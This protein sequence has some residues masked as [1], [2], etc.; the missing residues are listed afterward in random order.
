M[1][2]GQAPS[3]SQRRKSLQS[4]GKRGA[5]YFFFGVSFGCRVC[6]KAGTLSALCSSRVPLAVAFGPEK[7]ARL[8]SPVVTSVSSLIHSLMQCILQLLL[9]TRFSFAYY[10][11]FRPFFRWY[12]HPVWLRLLLHVCQVISDY[13]ERHHLDSVSSKADHG[14]PPHA[15]SLDQL[16]GATESSDEVSHTGASVGEAEK[17]KGKAEEELA[18]TTERSK[19]Q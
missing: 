16:H 11:S 6:F 10:P 18:D 9:P 15:E 1:V 13:R 12:A 3:G 5:R 14:V 4:I 17:T 8:P 2:V 19:T 7:L